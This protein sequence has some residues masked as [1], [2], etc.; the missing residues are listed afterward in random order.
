MEHKCR[1]FRSHTSETAAKDS[2]LVAVE[3]VTQE[4]LTTGE[5]VSGNGTDGFMY[6]E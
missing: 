6:V 2:M 4:T 3:A 1:Q 5:Y